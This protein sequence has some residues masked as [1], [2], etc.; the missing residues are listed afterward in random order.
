MNNVSFWELTESLGKRIKLNLI[1]KRDTQK[2]I[3]SVPKVIFNDKNEEYDKFYSFS[4]W[5]DFFSK[6][7]F[8]GFIWKG[9]IKNS[10]ISMLFL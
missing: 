7:I 6:T 3:T 9:T 10:Q 1:D 4:I 8:A 2:I 5:N